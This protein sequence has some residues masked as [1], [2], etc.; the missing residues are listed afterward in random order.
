MRTPFQI[1][2]SAKPQKFSIQLAGTTY[3]FTVR[4]NSVA[5][6]WILDIQDQNGVDLIMG[7]PMITGRDLLE[8]Y[9]DLRF[10]GALIVQTDGDS[11]AVPTYANLGGAGKLYF[12]VES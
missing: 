2:L 3:L 1:P 12:I 11:D 8:P 6:C 4:W 5:T 9:P 10:G 7:I